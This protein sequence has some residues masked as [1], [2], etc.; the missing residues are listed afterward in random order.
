MTNDELYEVAF[1]A[2]TRLYNDRSVSVATCKGNL[3]ALIGETEILL[4]ALGDAD[5]E[6]M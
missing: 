3:D 5:Q 4:D 6:E 2:I 1:K